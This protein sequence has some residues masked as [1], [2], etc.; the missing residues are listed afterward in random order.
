MSQNRIALT[1][2]ILKN[3]NPQLNRAE[4]TPGVVAVSRR[5][6]AGGLVLPAD[7]HITRALPPLLP[8]PN[9]LR[10]R[11]G[12]A[13]TGQSTINKRVMPTDLAR[14]VGIEDAVDDIT[15]NLY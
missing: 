7:L 8:S 11:G 9:K 15:I 12:V 14:A 3:T 4:R 6:K 5:Q 2:G 1:G 13:P 10:G